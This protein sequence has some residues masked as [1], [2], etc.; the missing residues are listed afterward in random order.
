MFIVVSA[1][2][3]FHHQ[4]IPKIVYLSEKANSLFRENSITIL[5]PKPLFHSFFYHSK[6]AQFCYNARKMKTVLKSVS[7]KKKRMTRVVYIMS[8]VA[9]RM[10]IE[11]S[12][13]I[14]YWNVGRRSINQALAWPKCTSCYCSQASEVL[15]FY[16]GLLLAIWCE[17]IKKRAEGKKANFPFCE[18]KH[19]HIGGK[20]ETGK[21]IGQLHGNI[22][23]CSFF[24]LRGANG[25]SFFFSLGK[26]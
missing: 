23:F 15:Y 10:D 2:Y 8:K 24:F 18:E 20:T 25:E 6:S 4:L 3:S 19:K 13:V 26:K 5:I 22:E 9:V 21:K 16:T 14:D 17:Q 7:G 1:S 11:F 12:I